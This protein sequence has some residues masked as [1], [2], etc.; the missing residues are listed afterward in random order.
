M[1]IMVSKSHGSRTA[2]AL[3]NKLNIQ[4]GHGLEWLLKLELVEVLLLVLGLGVVCVG[5]S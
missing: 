1:D 5:S 2:K 4:H 3:V